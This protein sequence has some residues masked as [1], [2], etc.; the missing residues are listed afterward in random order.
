VSTRRRLDVGIAAALF[1]FSLIPLVILLRHAHLANVAVA[2]SDGPFPADQFQYM[3]WIRE[4]G[5]GLLASN[6]F[7]IEESDRIFMHPMFFLSG[8]LWRVGVPV[9]IAFLVWKP[10]AVAVLFLGVRAYVARFVEGTWSR[11]AAM[12]LALFTAT[13]AVALFGWGE[14]G[15]F[16]DQQDVLNVTGEMLPAT[17]LWGYIPSAIAV[18]LMPLFLLGAERI[19]AAATAGQ[20]VPRGLVA[21]TSV[22]GMSAAWLH[23][24]QGEILLV[25]VGGAILLGRVARPHFALTVPLAAVVAPIAYYFLLSRLD[26]PWGRAADYNASEG[27]VAVWA[28]AAVVAPLAVLAVLGLRDRK[29]EFGER[30][31]WIWPLAA[32]AVYLVLAP[33]FPQHAFEGLSIPL[34]ILA[35]RGL[36]RLRAP[37][38]A[39]AAV[40]VALVVPG[41]AYMVDWVRD[42]T[43]APG[44]P[45]YLEHGEERALDY[46]DADAAGGD[47]LTSSYLGPLVPALTGRQ[48]WVG[49]PSWTPDFE[50]R[51]RDVRAMFDGMLPRERA[52]DLIRSSGATYVLVDC[53]GPEVPLGS[54][55]PDLA[56]ERRFGCATVYRVAAARAPPG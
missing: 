31:L 4:F 14:L 30:M 52:L 48:T 21:L 27:S 54:L 22:A 29:P 8:L 7:G 40:V 9:D 55:E 19:V 34:S 26:D 6:T 24:W 16:A 47:V 2:G 3:A 13:P 17:L 20:P 53:E 36:G 10:V 32:A 51:D 56:L 33:S 38:L 35:V 1:A 25:T 5:T 37:A 50:A 49:H 15:S 39:T 28:I 43:R 44:Q 18:G 23:P 42:V 45:H 41:L 11:A 46:L 12:V